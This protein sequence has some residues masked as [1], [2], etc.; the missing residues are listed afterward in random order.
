MFDEQLMIFILFQSAIGIHSIQITSLPPPTSE[1][2]SDSLDD[3]VPMRPR[4]IKL[5]ANLSHNLSFETA[6]D[7]PTTQIAELGPHDW[8][9]K[10]GTAQLQLRFVRFQNVNSLVMFIFDGC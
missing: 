9:D 6:E 1:D 8:D 2:D 7:F 5:Y 10:T 3:E 4:Q